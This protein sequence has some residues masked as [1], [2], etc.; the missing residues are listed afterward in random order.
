MNLRARWILF[1]LAPGAA[2]MAQDEEL[3]ISRDLTPPDEFK[4]IEGPAVSADGVLYAVNF[5]RQG[6]IG[7][8]TA[9]GHAQLFLELSALLLELSE[10]ALGMELFRLRRA[11]SSLLLPDDVVRLV[12]L[13]FVVLRPGDLRLEI[14]LV[15]SLEA[16]VPP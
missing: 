13:L 3:Y 1:L 12:A 11:E 10:G 8:V 2:A 9:D 6:T 16:P 14:L 15:R 5:Q 4:A 7:S